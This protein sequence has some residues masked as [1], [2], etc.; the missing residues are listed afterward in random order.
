[1]TRIAALRGRQLPGYLQKVDFDLSISNFM[2]RPSNGDVVLSDPVH[3]LCD[4]SA[5]WRRYLEGEP[6]IFEKR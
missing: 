5:D 4:V 1:M 6:V 3:G 2:V